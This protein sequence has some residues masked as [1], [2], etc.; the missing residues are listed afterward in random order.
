MRRAKIITLIFNVMLSLLPC[1]VQAQRNDAAVVQLQKLNRVYRHLYTAY[2]DSVNMESM[3]ESGIKAM[4]EELDPHSVYLDKKEMKASQEV[5]EGEFSGIGVEYN[6]LNDTI[7]VVNT[8]QQGPAESVGMMA[9]DRIVEIDGENVVGIERA[10]VPSRL[11]G[12]KGSIVEVSVVRR[13]V[14]EV[15]HFSITRDK[16]PITTVDAAYKIKDGIGYIKVNRFGRTT[17]QE[18]E[19][20]VSGLGEINTLVLDLSSNGGGLLDQAIE[21]AGY[22]IP[23]DS[24]VVFTEGRSIEPRY[25]RAKDGGRFAGRVAVM[26][27]ESSASASEIVAGAIQD[28]DRGV[29]IGRDSF[30]KGLVQSQI[31]LGDGSAIRLTVARYHTPSGRVIQRPYEM[32]HKEEYH[33]AHIERLRAVGKDTTALSGE[34]FATRVLGREVYGGGGIRPDVVVESDTTLVS[35]YMVK[36]I[37]KSLYNEFLL[38]YLDKHRGKLKTRYPT[39]EKFEAEFRLS[40]DEMRSLVERA[41]ASGV[42]YDEA[43]YMQSRELMRAQLTAMIAQRLFSTT[44]YYRYINPRVNDTYCRVLEILDNWDGDIGHL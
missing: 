26:I 4:L 9:N 36:V 29:I 6:I 38:D 13:G 11:R 37:A 24:L 42:E 14:K 8:V 44:E 27:N 25:Y 22:F 30:G 32:G 40:D 1:V 10:D 28:W 31:P 35:D 20:A 12:E 18:F 2:V 17:M 21:M 34:V 39:F 7:L 33:K 19:Q 43:G 41:T 23:R 16:I 15:L 3:V 5:T